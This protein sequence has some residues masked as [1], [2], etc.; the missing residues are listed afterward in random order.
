[1]ATLSTFGCSILSDGWTSTQNRPLINLL[2]ATPRGTKF[3]FAVDTSGATKDAVYIC[4]QLAK[5]ITLCGSE[6]VISVCTD[7]ASVN[8]AAAELLKEQFP[9]ITW[10]RCGAH[11]LNLVLGGR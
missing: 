1:M 9:H 6:H 8:E 4:Q 3:L 2:V 11:A 7:S 5:A 10:V